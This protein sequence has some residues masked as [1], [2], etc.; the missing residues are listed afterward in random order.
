MTQRRTPLPV[1]VGS[2]GIN[3]AG[4]VSFNHAY[5]RMVLESL[6][7]KVQQTTLGSLA[8]LMGLAKCDN[9]DTKAQILDGTLVRKIEHFDVERIAWHNAMSLGKDPDSEQTFIVAKRQLPQTLPEDWRVTSLDDKHALVRCVGDLNVFVQD[10][11]PSRVT[12]AGQ[13]PTGFDPAALYPSRSHPRGL[14][15]TVYG[16]SDAL[17]STGFSIDE[18]KSLVR[19]DQFAVYSGSAMGQLDQDGYG[20]L[21]Q[22]APGGER[23]PAKKNAPGLP[24]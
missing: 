7:Q 15:M 23:T 2:G 12:S 9:D 22:N 21:M 20:G 18:L 3:P 8:K 10:F 24:T 19:P 16:A 6:P 1:I 4:R 17:R 13:L 11:R 5:R 14:Q